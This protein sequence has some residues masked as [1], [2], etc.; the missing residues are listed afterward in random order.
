[1]EGA[2]LG[3]WV[4]TLTLAVPP[5]LLVVLALLSRLEAWTIQPDERAAKVARLLEQATAPE[6]LEIEVSRLFADVADTRRR[7]PLRLR[8]RRAESAGRPGRDRR[9]D[10]QANAFPGRGERRHPATGPDATAH[11]RGRS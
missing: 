10:A 8:V 3:W 2:N 11:S 1:M 9:R 4:P 7:K 6:E 5:V